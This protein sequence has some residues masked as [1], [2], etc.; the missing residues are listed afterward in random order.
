MKAQ[1]EPSAGQLLAAV[2]LDML[3]PVEQFYAIC[4]GRVKF[5]GYQ[6]RGLRVYHWNGRRCV[7]PS[8]LK[9]FVDE[10][11]KEFVPEESANE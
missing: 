6:R 8:E 10:H 3:V 11:A 5:I 7:K 2:H 4:G 1:V 9:K